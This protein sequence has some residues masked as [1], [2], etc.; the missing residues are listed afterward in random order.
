MSKLLDLY[1]RKHLSTYRDGFVSPAR[2]AR[3]LR[4]SAA[5]RLITESDETRAF[6]TIVDAA[7]EYFEERRND[8]LDLPHS[9]G[10]RATVESALGL[11]AQADGQE[12]AG[13]GD[14]RT[15]IDALRHGLQG[16]VEGMDNESEVLMFVRTSLRSLSDLFTQIASDDEGGGE[17]GDDPG[18]PGA[19]AGFDDP[20]PQ[21]P[22]GEEDDFDAVPPEDDPAPGEDEEPDSGLNDDQSLAARLGLA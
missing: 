19:D 8:V 18:D 22:G 13:N 17:G 15:R 3:A 20:G 9:S 1:Y 14:L 21:D 2:R 4:E 12:I 10:E 11:L 6:R 7:R 16:L 5:R